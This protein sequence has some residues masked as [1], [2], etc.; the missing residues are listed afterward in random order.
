MRPWVGLP[1]KFE[2]R[3]EVLKDLPDGTSDC[4]LIR[5]AQQSTGPAMIWA[6]VYVT[7]EC[8]FPELRKEICATV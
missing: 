3:C 2:G 8:S 1:E 4:R 5:A 7:G 6:G